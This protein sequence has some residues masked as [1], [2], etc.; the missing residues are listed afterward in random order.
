[1]RIGV[2]GAGSI[3]CHVGGMLAAADMAVVLVGRSELGEA[4]Q[5]G[6]ELTAHDGTHQHT[7]PGQFV[8]A[9]DAS[10]LAECDV[11]LVCVKSGDTAAAGEVLAPHLKEEAI[12]VSLQNGVGNV[13]ILRR[14]LPGRTV[15]AAMVGFNVARIGGNRFHRGTEGE[16]V[17]QEHKAAQALAR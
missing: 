10:A 2:L 17:L 15:L 3:G 5:A 8:F 4:L 12:V 13:A 9:T 14:A 16:I 6:I 7:A 1:M 11:I